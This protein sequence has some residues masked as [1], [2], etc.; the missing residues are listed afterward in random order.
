MDNQYF[1]ESRQKWQRMADLWNE[2]TPPGRPSEDDIANYRKLLDVVLNGSKCPKIVMMGSTPELRE[3]L[4]DYCES[5]GS[6]L[7]C[8]D[9]TEDMYESMT[10]LVQ[11]RSENE[12]FVRSNWLEMAKHFETGSIDVVIGDYVVGNIGEKRDELYREINSMLKKDGCFITRNACIDQSTLVVTD[13]SKIFD[14]CV[15]KARAGQ[16]TA[17]EASNFFVQQINFSSW[18]Q[19]K[20]NEISLSYYADQLDDLEKKEANSEDPLRKEI[21][22]IYLNSWGKMTDKVWHFTKRETEES[23]MKKH[24]EI[25]ETLYSNDYN[26]VR[27]SP[28]Y[29]LR[30]KS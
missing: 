4:S 10:L 20:K 29:L 5:E 16:L 17:K 2:F 26:I 1:D 27:E 23:F 19:N 7:A 8:V 15:E 21:M 9:M 24:F 30:K 25:A 18:Y 14:D 28:I 22:A 11:K 13:I 12:R 6:E 3:L